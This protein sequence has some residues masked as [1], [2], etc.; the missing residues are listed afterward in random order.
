MS[1]IHRLWS[2]GLALVTPATATLVLVHCSSSSSP[3]GAPAGT[4]AAVGPTVDASP[5]AAPVD[6]GVPVE[7]ATPC[8]A[9]NACASPLACC[10]GFCADLRHDPR[11]CG[12]CGNGCST[13]QFCTGTACDDVTFPNVCSNT[14]ILV[15]DDPYPIDD[16]AGA[17]IGSAIQS[18]AVGSTLSV[19]P[20][21]QPGIL[22][23]D[24]DAGWRPNTG[25]S[26]TMVAGG[27][28][29]GQLSVAY[30]DDHGLTPVYLV[31]DGTTS[32]IYQRSTGLAL[33]TTPDS[34]LTSQ[35][36]YFILEMTVEPQSG[37]LCVIGEGILSPGTTAAGYYGAAVVV[38]N[39]NM[40]PSAWYVYEWTDTSG[41]GQPG[42]GDTFSMVGD[43]T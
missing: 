2:S 20:Q 16:E 38:P 18:C 39:R 3:G 7:A 8:D 24:G 14:T 13:S 19:V 43:G 28:W 6:A 31:N 10:S 42:P 23:P 40:Y 35:H 11:N 33:V 41:D 5:E 36:D 12:T 27:S 25:G 32:H 34:A 37:T 15:V 9:A 1:A 26:T 4:D 29:F 17:A 30:L 22:V 21:T